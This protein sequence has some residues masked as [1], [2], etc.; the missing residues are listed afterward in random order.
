MAERVYVRDDAGRFSE[1]GG[2]VTASRGDFARQES[3]VARLREVAD[4]SESFSAGAVFT[5]VRA[6]EEEGVPEV[7]D[8]DFDKAPEVSVN[9]SEVVA[10]QPTLSAAVVEGYIR[11]PD[12]KLPKVIRHGRS[13]FL[14]DGHHQ[15]AAKALLGIGSF[16]AK[17]VVSR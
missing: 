17:L 14:I 15:V 3:A 12:Q 10:T 9:L 7:P 11:N 8:S 2:G 5:K 16:R 13:L 4:G 6:A 1:S